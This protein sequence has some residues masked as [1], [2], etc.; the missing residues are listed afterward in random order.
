MD[1]AKRG[2]N[3]KAFIYYREKRGDFQLIF[4]APIL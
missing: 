4:P 2:I 1:L 3:G